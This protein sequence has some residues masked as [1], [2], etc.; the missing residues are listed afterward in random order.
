MLKHLLAIYSNCHSRKAAGEPVPQ[1]LHMVN[2]VWEMT[3]PE[4]LGEYRDIY[5]ALLSEEHSQYEQFRE[6]I[7]PLYDMF[8]E[9]GTSFSLSYA[10]FTDFMNALEL[11]DD[12][13][14]KL[15]RYIV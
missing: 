2:C 15:Q 1:Y 8:D 12:H 6:E 7:L 10:T 9:L 14:F 4:K 3:D 11:D 13:A 5:L